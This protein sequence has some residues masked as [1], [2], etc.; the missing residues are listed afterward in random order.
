M[1]DPTD[2]KQVPLEALSGLRPQKVDLSRCNMLYARYY[3]KGML[4][5][6]NNR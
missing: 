5:F 4:T 1:V 2:L 3:L 6:G